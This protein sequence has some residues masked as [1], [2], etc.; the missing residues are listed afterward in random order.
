MIWEKAEQS[1]QALSHRRT[2]RE[3]CLLRVSL[4]FPSA[5]A[6]MKPLE[7]STEIIGLNK[8]SISWPPTFS[9]SASP[10][11][12]EIISSL[13]LFVCL[14]SESEERKKFWRDS[15][16]KGNPSIRQEAMTLRKK[17]KS[18]LNSSLKRFFKS[19]NEETSRRERTDVMPHDGKKG[20]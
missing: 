14:S 1:V 10:V 15:W 20:N 9:K 2:N 7:M 19:H 4:F 16:E 8:R 18:S 11:R 5:K 17:L 6:R 13:R 3:V 12:R